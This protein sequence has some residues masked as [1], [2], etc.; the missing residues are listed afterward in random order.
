MWFTNDDNRT[1]KRIK[2]DEKE[3]LAERYLFTKGF[4][5]IERNFHCKGGEIDLIMKDGEYLV[6]IEVRYRKT[7]GFGGALAS[8]TQ[9]K[10]RKLNRAAEY[11]LLQHYKNTPPPCRIDAIGIEGDDHIEWIKNAF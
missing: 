8:I 10:Q 11:Y 4:E 1:E 6:F 2:G 9:S 3:Y 5:L 7:K